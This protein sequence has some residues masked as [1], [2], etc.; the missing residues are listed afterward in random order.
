MQFLS[1]IWKKNWII[2]LD[3]LEH[4]GT[5]AQCWSD[6]YHSTNCLPCLSHSKSKREKNVVQERKWLY[7]FLNNHFL[8]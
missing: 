2:V 6:T 1:I 5:V 3:E 4:R 7:R 8:N